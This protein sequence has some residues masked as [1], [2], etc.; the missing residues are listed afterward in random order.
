MNNSTLHRKSFQY[1]KK[2][3]NEKGLTPNHVIQLPKHKLRS[4][5][6]K[7]SSLKE[8]TPA[9]SL[10]NGKLREYR[11]MTCPTYPEESRQGLANCV[12]PENR[13]DGSSSGP[14]WKTKSRVAEILLLGRQPLMG[15]ESRCSEK[16]RLKSAPGAFNYRPQA[17][18]ASHAH[19]LRRLIWRRGGGRNRSA[20][21]I[22]RAQ[23]P[24]HLAAHA[25]PGCPPR[26]VFPGI[27][28]FQLNRGPCRRHSIHCLALISSAIGTDFLFIDEREQRDCTAPWKFH[29]KM[30]DHSAGRLAL[31][32][33]D[34]S[35]PITY[36]RC[37]RK[38]TDATRRSKEIYL[39]IRKLNCE[40]TE[41]S[42]D[43]LFEFLQRNFGMSIS[44]LASFS[45]N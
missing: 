38:I 27:V 11:N 13:G 21:S 17:V 5:L 24:R 42:I 39:T 45:V 30:I 16:L 25:F 12:F 40:S 15:S 28:H 6:N 36:S 22:S 43:P 14:V 23:F 37:L 31:E 20:Y 7:S 9:T 10:K 1:S 33:P 34:Y 3:S 19:S 41:L 2:S 32:L 26:R 29:L 4:T 8:L 44:L 35:K 18:V